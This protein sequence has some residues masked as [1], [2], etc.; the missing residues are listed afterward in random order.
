MRF[1]FLFVLPA[2]LFILPVARSQKIKYSVANIHAHNDYEV[3]IPFVQAYRLGIGSIEADVILRNDTLYV[4]HDE[5]DIAERT[6]YFE[7]HYIRPLDAAQHTGKA[8]PV[9]LL[10]DLKTDAVTTLAKVV[11]VVE[12]YP[13]LTSNPD[14]QLVITG[15]QPPAENF[16]R[17]PRWM[18]FDGRLNN[19]AHFNHLDRIGMFSANFRDYTK[20]N[21]KG[22]IPEAE[23]KKI[24]EAVQRVHA[25]GK[26]IRFWASPDIINAWHVF[27]DMKIDFINTD[28]IEEL[29]VFMNRLPQTT[30]LPA[31]QYELYAP[32]YKTDRTNKKVK[33]IILMI[34]DGT[35]L[36]Q[37]YAGYTGNKGRLNVFNMKSIGLSI[38]RSAD[39]YI[40]ESAAGASAIAT[41]QKTNNNFVAVLPDGSS[42]PSI[43]E[44][45]A[46]KNIR[47]AVISTGNITDATPA[48]FYAHVPNRNL[49]GQI[50]ESFL[51]SE[52]DIL[53]GSGKRH[54]TKR[55]NGSLIPAIEQKGYTVLDN[56]QHI[57]TVKNKRLVILDEN[58]GKPSYKERGD[59]LQKALAFSTKTLKTHKPGFFIMAEGA[60]VDWASHEN[61]MEWMV[62]EVQDL[63]K[64]IGDMMRFVDENK[65]TLLI[66]T[67]DHETGG[68]TLLNGNLS[69]GKVQGHYASED[70]TA[71]CV[72]VF[73]YGPQSH[74]FSGVYQNTEI[75]KKIMQLIGK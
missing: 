10:I 14:I 11:E 65:E 70:H 71:I 16:S 24:Q 7:E 29:T 59:F 60:Q 5:K 44:W 26:K 37:W 55:T 56:I 74:L 57:D 47:S 6:L 9:I 51:S 64:A 41:G 13:A 42:V 53:I 1:Q 18:L 38:T 52:I 12:K 72:P 69:S 22:L 34:G 61:Q 35:G 68:L 36:A 28:R 67:A 23:R 17:Y 31:N 25:A 43:P 58:A 49:S 54:F 8:R 73:A 32:L 63:D 4:A 66:V 62:Q 21:G 33:N 19:P 45:L 30:S 46:G 75:F 50:A 27:M 2:L 3:N 39:S 15:N 40:T 48:A 20:W